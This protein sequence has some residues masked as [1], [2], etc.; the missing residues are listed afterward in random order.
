[1]PHGQHLELV[2]GGWGFAKAETHFPTFLFLFILFLF[3]SFFLF[4]FFLMPSA[5]EGGG[6]HLLPISKHLALHSRLGQGRLMLGHP[7]APQT[8]ERR[9]SPPSPQGEKHLRLLDDPKAVPNHVCVIH[10]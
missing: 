8:L 3:F 2:S 9:V 6:G 1:V 7:P 4:L 5:C 10:S